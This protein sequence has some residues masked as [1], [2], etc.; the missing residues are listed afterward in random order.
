VSTIL[1]STRATGHTARSKALTMLLQGLLVFQQARV[2]GLGRGVAMVYAEQ[3]FRGQRTRAHRFMKNTP[4]DTWET[5][6]AWLAPRTPDLRQVCI[7]VE[8]TALGACRGLEA[9]LIVEGRGLAFSRLFVHQDALKHRQT[10]VAWT[11]WS[12]LSA[13]RQAGHTFLGTVE[14]GCAKCDWVGASPL[15]PFRPLLLRLKRPPL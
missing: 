14:R 3:S 13:M 4:I 10:L 12:A 11:M 2:A 15:Y 9:W 8:W 1:R 5:G 7:A 6:A